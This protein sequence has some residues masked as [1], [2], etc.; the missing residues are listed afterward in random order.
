MTTAGAYRILIVEDEEAVGE[1][2]RRTIQATIHGA[3]AL[4]VTDFERAREML[5]TGTFDAVVLDLF[6]GAVAEGAKAGQQVW[7][8][9]W[10]GRLIPVL[11]HTAGDCDLSPPIPTAHPLL[12]CLKKGAGSDEEV[13]RSLQ[14]MWPYMAA[15]HQVE[16]QFLSAVKRV[17]VEIAPIIWGAER[18]EGKR[19]E[20]LLRT[21]RRRI[22]ALMDVTTLTVDSQLQSWEQYI[23]PPLEDCLLTGDI[24]RMGDASWEKVDA[25]RVVLS[26]SCDLVMRGGKARI[27]KVLVAKCLSIEEYERRAGGQLPSRLN[28]AHVGGY[29]PLPEYP[30]IVP[31]M[32]ACLRDLELVPIAEI[33]QHKTFYRTASIDS[34]FREQLAWAYLQISS[35]PGV[36]ERNTESWAEAIR[37]QTKKPGPQK[38]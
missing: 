35:R 12:K 14:T 2:L 23:V 19:Q 31:H 37:Q 6:A 8:D 17:L 25:H 33:G 4:L 34:P 9:I 36:P 38:G 11:I 13:A 20:F 29:V 32:A 24:L 15:L 27:D 21:A 1:S 16:G 26:P 28:D 10:R 18:D 22:A 30:S 7:D 5:R 3:D